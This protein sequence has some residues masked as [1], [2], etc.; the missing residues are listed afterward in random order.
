MKIQLIMVGRTTEKWLQEGTGQ[1]FGRL[2]HY[3]PFEVKILTGVKKGGKLTPEELK[4]KEGN[5]ILKN[6][7]TSD[8]LV[9]LDEN[10]KKF[11]S[12]EFAGFLEKQ[13]ITGMRRL[14]FVIGGAWGFSDEVYG[15]ADFKISLSPMT[16]SHQIV[17]L[18][19]A[20]QLYRAL[21]ILNHEPYHHD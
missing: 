17:R 4:Q 18:I 11:S 1:Y 15:R 8:C 7:D 16:F 12:R 2:K 9:L 19:F 10:G 14:V 6:I 20:E 3:L 21:T 5:D 13:M